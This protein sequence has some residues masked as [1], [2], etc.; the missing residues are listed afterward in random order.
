MATHIFDPYPHQ[1]KAIEKIQEKRSSKGQRALVVVPTGGGKTFIATDEA[2]REVENGGSVL[3]LAHREKLLQQMKKEIL[4]FDPDADIGLVGFG[5][6]EWGH[7]ITLGGVQTLYRSQYRL[8]RLKTEHFT[9]VI[10]DEAH[11]ILSPGYQLIHKYLPDAFYLGITAT[12]DRGDGGDAADFYGMPVF[13]ISI[14]ELI[15]QGFLCDLKTFV[16]KTKTDIKD[17]A[18]NRNNNEYVRTELEYVINC[19]DRNHLIAKSCLDPELGGPDIA[20][21]CFCAGKEH[22]HNL[23]DSFNQIGI[24]AQ[25]LLSETTKEER[26]QIYQDF[27]S[28][29][30]KVITNVGVCE[31]GWDADVR[32]VVLAAPTQVRAKFCQRIGRGTRL[33]PGKE[34]CYLLDFSDD[35]ASHDLEPVGFEEVFEMPIFDGELLSSAA[36]KA[37]ERQARQ[38]QDKEKREEI[39]REMMEWSELVNKE[40]DILGAK[41]PWERMPGGGYIVNVEESKLV[42]VPGKKPGEFSVG[43]RFKRDEFDNNHDDVLDRKVPLALAMSTVEKKSRQIQAGAYELVDPDAPWKRRA[44]SKDQL[45]KLEL[46]Q[47]IGKVDRNIPISVLSQGE[48]DTMISRVNA[49]STKKPRKKRAKKS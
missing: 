24:T 8:E 44:I 36:E 33:A 35:V 43:I 4:L 5:F 16:I 3:I 45:R 12:T 13:I 27:A 30:L 15:K 10:T 11:H 28:G 31:E 46:L 34:F 48:A 18:I 49:G 26:W 21:V 17:V 25:V 38:E 29:K 22:A 14:R 7:K 37:L 2:R 42:I 39:L 9:Y 6:A 41:L 23:A 19:E 40:V 47:R 20:T 32:R 1:A